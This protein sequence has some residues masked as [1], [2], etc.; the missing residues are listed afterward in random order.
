MSQYDAHFLALLGWPKPKVKAFF[1][2]KFD[3]DFVFDSDG[4]CIAFTNRTFVIVVNEWDKTPATL[5]LLTH[6]VLH[7][8]LLMLNQ[9]GQGVCTRDHEHLTYLVQHIFQMI[10]EKKPRRR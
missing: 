1:R 8:A 6:E 4:C 2:K 10:L 3:Y 9:I 5:A 7:G